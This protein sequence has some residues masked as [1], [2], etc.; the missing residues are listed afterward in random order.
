VTDKENNPNDES[1]SDDINPESRWANLALISAVIIFSICAA[2]YLGIYFIPDRTSTVKVETHI[3]SIRKDTGRESAKP[4]V[5]VSG[6]NKEEQKD[7]LKKDSSLSKPN[8]EISSEKNEVSKI[9]PSP[10]ASHWSEGEP[11][12]LINI[13]SA[14]Q[15]ALQQLPF[16]GP[17]KAQAIVQYRDKHGKFKKTSDIIKIPGI[18]KKTYE[19]IKDLIIID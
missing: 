1:T 6:Q 3:S 13:N 5:I 2:I 4:D 14:P 10:A 19:Q 15:E 8:E 9:K 16:I 7:N 18:G 17:V 11:P 12:I